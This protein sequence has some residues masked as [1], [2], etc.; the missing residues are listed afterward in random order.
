[1]KKE[2]YQA[3]TVTGP[4]GSDSGGLPMRMYVQRGTKH[5]RLLNDAPSYSSGP[6][7]VF[8]VVKGLVRAPRQLVV[9]V[10]ERAD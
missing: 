3:F 5:E 9:E 4:D 8:Y 7:K 1:M 2:Q 10:L 6:P